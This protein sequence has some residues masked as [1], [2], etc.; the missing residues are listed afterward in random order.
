MT[1]ETIRHRSCR[2]GLCLIML[3]SASHL[4]NLITFKYLKL[5]FLAILIASVQPDPVRSQYFGLDE[6]DSE[7]GTYWIIIIV[8]VYMINRYRQQHL[9]RNRNRNLVRD[10]SSTGIHPGYTM[11]RDGEQR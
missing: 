1:H 8:L 3:M 7:L 6:E 5:S 4:E 10:E 11:W 9:E 2:Y